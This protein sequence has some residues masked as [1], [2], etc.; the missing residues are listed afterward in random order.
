M[1]SRSATWSLVANWNACDRRLSADIHEATKSL[2]ERI[3]QPGDKPR[4]L[5]VLRGGK[6][7]TFEVR[8]GLLKVRWDIKLIPES[9][10]KAN[11][12]SANAQEPGKEPGKETGKPVEQKPE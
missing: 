11:A 5:V 9:W 12:T 3:K 6:A 2:L 10:V 8:S 1:A 4:K 7:V